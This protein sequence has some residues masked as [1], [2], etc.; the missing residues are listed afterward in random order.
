MARW[1]AVVVNAIALCML[2]IGMGTSLGCCVRRFPRGGRTQGMTLMSVRPDDAATG[3]PPAKGWNFQVEVYSTAGCS[4]CR[5]AK[6]RLDELGVPYLTFD[7]SGPLRDDGT[8]DS[9]DDYFQ[10][11]KTNVD[12]IRRSRHA[13]ARRNTVPQIYV[14]YLDGKN[15]SDEAVRVGGFDDLSRELEDGTFQR[16]LG[17]TMPTPVVNPAAAEMHPATPKQE[18][19]VVEDPSSGNTFL[20]TLSPSAVGPAAAIALS[21]D[22]QRRALTLTDK[23]AIADG[24]RVDYNAM[25]TSDAFAQVHVCTPSNHHHNHHRAHLSCKHFMQYRAVAARL[26][27][28]PFGSLVA[29]PAPARLAFFVNLYNAM[30]LHATCVLGPPEVRHP[31]FS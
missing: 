31:S 24:S 18:N 23:F 26:H 30:V 29:L 2:W 28:I 17:G 21:Q 3:T 7:I 14:G 16:R 9:G 13:H 12:G 1:L 20:N 6:A 8:P 22:L 11:N 25:R 4:F 15:I 19:A 27:S 5:K 10:T